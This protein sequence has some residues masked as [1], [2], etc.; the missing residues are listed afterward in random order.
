MTTDYINLVPLPPKALLEADLTFA[1][2]WLRDRVATSGAGRAVGSARAVPLGAIPTPVLLGLSSNAAVVASS[3]DAG[4]YDW[5]AQLLL[6][7]G[8]RLEMGKSMAFMEWLEVTGH[9]AYDRG[10]TDQFLQLFFLSML[11]KA[12]VRDVAGNS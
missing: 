4:D 7:D 1:A 3:I 5:R 11:L 6:T 10:D 9:A 8:D 2:G 12:R